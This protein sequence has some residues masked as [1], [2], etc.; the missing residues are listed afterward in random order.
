[1]KTVQEVEVLVYLQSG[2]TLFYAWETPAT[3]GHCFSRGRKWAAEAMREQKVAG[4]SRVKG[5]QVTVRL[6]GRPWRGGSAS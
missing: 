4:R 2:R 6:T 1:M 3:F 5:M